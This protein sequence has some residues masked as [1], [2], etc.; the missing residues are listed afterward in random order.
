MLKRTLPLAIV[1]L[2]PLLPLSAQAKP[3]CDERGAHATLE[4]SD[5]HGALPNRALATS[6]ARAKTRATALAPATPVAHAAPKRAPLLPVTPV[7]EL[8]PTRPIATPATPARP[9]AAVHNDSAPRIGPLVLSHQS[10]QI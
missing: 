4:L 10:F 7:S 5:T 8:T 6:A 9:K 3:C 1:L 2:A